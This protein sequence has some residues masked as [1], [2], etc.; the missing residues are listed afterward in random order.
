MVGAAARGSNDIAPGGSDFLDGSDA[1]A[2][3]RQGRRQRRDRYAGRAF[4]G[5]AHDAARVNG[6]TPAN[7]VRLVSPASDD[8]RVVWY[9]PMH[10]LRLVAYTSRTGTP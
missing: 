7:V 3:M 9:H 8:N 1:N 10:P 6:G 2:P 5:Y 4:D